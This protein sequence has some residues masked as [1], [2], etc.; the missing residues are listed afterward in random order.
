MAHVKEDFNFDSRDEINVFSS[1]GNAAHKI[2][3]VRVA[4]LHPATVVHQWYISSGGVIF[5]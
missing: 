4:T 3:T 1:Q 2:M 5:S